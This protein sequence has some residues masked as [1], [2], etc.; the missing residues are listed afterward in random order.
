M[1]PTPAEVNGWEVLNITLPLL[2]LQDS[3][4]SMHGLGENKP[5]L[6]YLFHNKVGEGNKSSQDI[7]AISY[8][9]NILQNFVK[10][11]NLKISSF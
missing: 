11:G 2:L 1:F 5:I 9:S 7:L 4:V 3:I 8:S 6:K 10:T